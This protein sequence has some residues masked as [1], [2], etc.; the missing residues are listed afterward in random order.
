MIK[1]VFIPIINDFSLLGFT[2]ERT[3]NKGLY[4][5]RIANNLKISNTNLTFETNML[6]KLFSDS[7]RDKQIMHYEQFVNITHE[8][9]I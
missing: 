3:E 2:K 1:L 8:L 5:L 6:K 4:A 7:Y 9:K